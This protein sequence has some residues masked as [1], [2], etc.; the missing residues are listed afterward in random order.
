MKIIYSQQYGY[1][2]SSWE[3][4]RDI[5]KIMLLWE[6]LINAIES[7]E[8]ITEYHP[9]YLSM[10]N[11]LCER[12]PEEKKRLS[13][14]KSYV[15]LRDSIKLKVLETNNMDFYIKEYDGFEEIIFLDGSNNDIWRFGD[16]S[17]SS[18]R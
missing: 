17:F 10:M 3:P 1:G 15:T 16:L 11:Y 18:L 9:A 12:F 8:K 5:K 4:N 13:M 2:W 7:N 6:P 14:D